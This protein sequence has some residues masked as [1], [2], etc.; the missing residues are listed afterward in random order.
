M[1]GVLEKRMA[2]NDLA[3]KVDAEVVKQGR[4]VATHRGITLAEYFSELLKG[5]VARDYRDALT[6]MADEI[7]SVDPDRAPRPRKG[8]G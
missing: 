8:K 2:R 6:A 3:V 4:I 7:P 5:P 1:A